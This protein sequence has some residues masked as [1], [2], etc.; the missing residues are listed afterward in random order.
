MYNWFYDTSQLCIVD[1]S[2]GRVLTSGFDSVVECVCYSPDGT[3]IAFVDRRFDYKRQSQKSRVGI[4]DT[5]T[6]KVTYIYQLNDQRAA[7]FDVSWS[8]DGKRLLVGEAFG[9]ETGGRTGVLT[10]ASK[11]LV[12]L[13]TKDACESR[14]SPDGH[15]IVVSQSTQAYSA[16]SLARPNGQIERVLSRADV[17]DRSGPFAGSF[18]PDGLR[19]VYALG[20]GIWTID[21]D[22]SNKVMVIPDGRDPAW[23]SR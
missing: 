22:G 2:G 3:R 9:E 7:G 18:S 11:T 1:A 13:P 6:E 5:R 15:S 14:W 4:F 19:I 23:S 20:A 16:V 21:A 17:D 10:I 12:W 8:P